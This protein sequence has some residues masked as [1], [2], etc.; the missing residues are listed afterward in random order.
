VNDLI[1]ET[2][3]W[4][5]DEHSKNEYDNKLTEFNGKINPVMMKI[6][7]QG[8]SEM[9]EAVPTEDL[10]KDTESVPTIDEVD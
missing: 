10:S 9:P 3:L 8:G 7:S 6:Y 1:T 2:E 5:E 4:F